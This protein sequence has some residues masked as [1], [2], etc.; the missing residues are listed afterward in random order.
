MPDGNAL[1]FI[2]NHDNQRG[3]GAGGAAIATFW[4]PRIHKMAVAYMLAHPYGVA[5]V[6]S[7]F[8]WDRNFVNGKVCVRSGSERRCISSL[9][10]FIHTAI[11]SCIP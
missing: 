4:D 7:S 5:R 11:H 9:C 1:V 6:M 8:R 2:D 3:H 10:C